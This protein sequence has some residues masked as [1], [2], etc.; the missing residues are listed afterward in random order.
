MARDP[1]G[2]GCLL[3]TWDVNGKESS[4]LEQIYECIYIHF[5]VILGFSRNEQMRRSK[6]FRDNANG[7]KYHAT[8]QG[9][10]TFL[11]MFQENITFPREVQKCPKNSQY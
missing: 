8:L 10:S 5:E 3:G 11:E 6:T 1:E 9:T 2:T 4:G 7:A